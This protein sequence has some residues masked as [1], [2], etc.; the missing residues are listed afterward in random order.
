MNIEFVYSTVPQSASQDHS[1]NA[2][3]FYAAGPYFK[4]TH[5]PGQLNPLCSPTGHPNS[6]PGHPSGFQANPS[7]PRGHPSGQTVTT[8]GP[9]GHQSGPTLDCD[10]GTSTITADI[11][12]ITAKDAAAPNDYPHDTST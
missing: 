7:G 1:T 10:I 5:T 9:E 3:A 11:Q 2:T 6:L 8:S 4:P 12:A